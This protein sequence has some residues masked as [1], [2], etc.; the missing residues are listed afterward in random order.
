M[1]SATPIAVRPE[2]T[3]TTVACRGEHS[4]WSGESARDDHRIVLVRSGRFR[5][6]ADGVVGCVD[7]A[8]G[9]IGMPGQ[10]ERFSHPC[11]DDTCTSIHIGRSLWESLAPNASGSWLGTLYVDAR[12]DL[13]HRRLLASVADGDVDYAVAERLLHLSAAAM[14][15]V[16]AGAVPAGGNSR[17]DHAM[18]AAACEAIGAGHPAADGLFPL[19]ALLSVSPYRLSRAFGRQLGVPLT[20]Y[21]NRVRVGH[22]LDAI[23]AGEEKLGAL[24]ARLGFA[25]QAHLTRTIRQHCGH[26]PSALRHILN[27]AD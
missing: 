1:L 11:G 13:A 23:E 19:A 12:L 4:G 8:V 21:R 6:R 16:M 5:R 10:V 3:V 25:D 22:A 18:V 17:A 9:Y 26:T 24:A 15:R 27:R 2:F 20:R 14:S 7:P